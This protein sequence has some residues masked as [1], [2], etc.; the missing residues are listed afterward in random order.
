VRIRLALLAIGVIAQGLTA[1]PVLSRSE[2]VLAK[3]CIGPVDAH[4]TA[5]DAAQDV[6]IAVF[7]DTLNDGELAQFRQQLVPFYMAARNKNPLR[8]AIILNGGVQFAGP[9][10]TRAQLEAALNGLRGTAAPVG[11]N[12]VEPLRLYSYL[13][14]NAQQFGSSWSTLAIIGHFPQI[15]QQMFNFTAGQLVL[16]FGSARVRVSYWSPSGETSAVLDA[17]VA[18]TGGMHLSHGLDDLLPAMKDDQGF[19]EISWQAPS[20]AVGFR[21]CPVTLSGPDGQTVLTIPSIAAAAGVMLPEME[22]YALVRAKTEAIAATLKQA[23][24]SSGEAHQAEADLALALEVSPR[25]EET[26][27]LGAILFKREANDAKLAEILGAQAQVAP[28]DAAVFEDLGHARYRM[29]D[30]DAADRAL[31]RARELKPGD[32]MVAEELARMRVTRGNDRGA[33]PFLDESLA[34]RSGNL[35][36]WLVRADVSTRLDDWRLALD[37]LEH[38][39][40]FGNIPLDRRTSLVRLYVQHQMPD[41]ALVQ[42]RAVAENLPPD[43]AVRSEYAE[44][45]EDLHAPDQ[46]LPAWRRALEID[47]ALEPAHYRI[48]ELQIGQNAF[49]EALQSAETGLQVAPRSARLYLAKAE[50][51]EKQNHFYEARR[52]LRQAAPI[53]PDAALLSRLAEMEDAGGENAAKYYRALAESSDASSSTSGVRKAALDRGMAAALRDGELDDVAWFQA[54]LGA[55]GGSV[56]KQPDAPE[57]SVTVPGGL[58]ALSFIAGSKPSSPARFFVEYARAISKNSGTA[59]AQI[60]REHFAR[61]AELAAFGVPQGGKVKVTVSASDR[62]S[63]KNAEK[64]LELLGWRMHGSRQGLKLEVIEKGERAK[65]QET[66]SALAIDEVSMQQA[67]ENGKPFSFDIPMEGASVL[68]G[69]EMW[70]SHFYPKERL[71]GGLAEAIAGNLPLAQTYAALGQMDPNTARILASG[72]GLRTLA[73]KYSSLLIQYSSA[74]AVAQGRVALPGGDAA[75]TT[76]ASLVG[77]DVRHPDLFFRAL[78]AKDD[79]KLLAYYAALSALDFRHQRFFTRTPAR[80]FKFYD[81]FREAPETVHSASKRIQTGSFVEFLSEVP[82]DKDGSVDFP[83]SPEVWMVA[84]GQSRSSTNVTKMMKKVT[85]TVAPEVEDEILLRLAGTR[86]KVGASSRSE[87]DNFLAVVRIDAHRTQPLDEESALVLAQH[88]AEDEAA[89]PYFA[90]LTGLQYKQFEKFFAFADALRSASAEDKDARI[91][92]LSTLVQMVCL[93]QEAGTISE[94]QGA[95]LVGQIVER[96]QS[97]G[98]DAERTAASLD[99]VRGILADA[100]PRA[101]R[102]PDTAMREMLLGPSAPA[103]LHLKGAITLVDYNRSRSAQYKQVLDLQKAPSLATVLALSDA[104]RNLGAGK[105]AAAQL[106]VLESGASGLFVVEAPKQLGLKGKERELVGG[107]EPRKLDEILKELREKTAKKKVNVK[108]LEKLSYDY[109]KELDLPVRWALQGII[110]AC[111]L[112]PGDLLVSEDPLLLRKHRF[113]SLESGQNTTR[114]FQHAELMQSSEKA[115]SY[116][117]GG[118]ADFA[119]AAGYAAAL[120][121]KLGGASGEFIASKQMAALRST[122]WGRLRDEDLRVVGL[123]IAVSREW[124]VHAANQ[125]D[126][127]TTLAEETLGLLSLTRRAEV[128]SALAEGNWRSVWNGIT[129][130]DSYFLADRFLERYSKDPWQSPALT[131]LR[132]RIAHDDGARLQVLG[133]EFDETFGCSHPHLRSGQPYEEYEKDIHPT[134]LA[135]RTAEFKLYLAHYADSAGIPAAALGALAEPSALVILK[136]M[137]VTDMHDWRSALEAYATLNDKV[138]EAAVAAR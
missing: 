131:E 74:L 121:G 26:L 82:L 105:D 128:L 62:T 78:L 84:K 111:Y 138:M 97:A 133:A 101:A 75:E 46:A 108:D 88:F 122:Q 23:S 68:L 6:L 21:V 90:S 124:I 96:L 3:T 58:A 29:R 72:I 25:E 28:D 102:D 119:D 37:S 110:Y 81:L 47:P 36:L 31:L 10:K 137:E 85:R 130:S 77:A 56:R 100:G 54:Q 123:K 70:R 42:V 30:W 19:R 22:R 17:V 94:T 7:A 13:A 89:Y 34:A 11:S 38:A 45:L 71:P 44:F 126:V 92:A 41:R 4:G 79:G 127:Q 67:L 73:D 33:L 61:I 39:A 76:W 107:F 106:Q 55:S 135:E 51:L 69:E 1:Q 83:G 8:L 60:I 15:D 52:T 57:S 66:A 109:L 95:E 125:P 24:L 35:D 2:L 87:L 112:S 65:H 64:I 104:V 27:R 113:V 118:F 59:R 116:F 91:A 114:V 50:I 99:L 12:T 117:Q 40:A 5:I 134:R 53:L 129:L 98:S 86:Y 43:V 16:H 32:A 80:T 49:D 103:E 63:Q 120:S 20:P 14:Q 115:G 132:Q 48:T 136:S 93:A 18:A 9:F